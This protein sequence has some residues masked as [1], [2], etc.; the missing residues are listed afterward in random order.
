MRLKSALTA[1]WLCLLAGCALSWATSAQALVVHPFAGSFGGEGS[2]SGQFKEP[3]G[4]AVNDT[5]HGVYVVDSANRRVQEFNSTGSTV[6]GEFNGS[7]A[8]TGV[9]SHP[10]QIAVDNS[11]NPLD[12][13]AG[14]VYVV[15]LGH[16]VVDK[17]TASGTYV[18]Q[19]TGTPSS[20]F[21]PFEASGAQVFGGRGE[22]G[23][24]RGLA[25]DPSGAV[26]VVWGT[27]YLKK[28]F[29]KEAYVDNFSD[30][31]ENQYVAEHPAGFALASLE[32]G[33][34][35][36]GE[37]DL[38]LNAERIRKTN[39]SG[40]TLIPTIDSERAS[41]VAVDPTGGEVYVDN[42]NY[43]NP[44]DSIIGAFSL[45]GAQIEQFG[46]GH[47]NGSS[48]VAVDGSDGT[49]YATSQSLDAVAIFNAV[50]LPSVTIGA[51]TE[52]TPRS[53]TLNGIVA[54][55]GQA[56]T[57]C[58]FEYG[59]TSAY[60]Q[61]VPCS[62]ASLGTGSSPVAVSAQ[63]TGLTPET[64]YHY[65]LV[66]TNTGGRSPTADRE[67]FTGP[68]IGGEFV[69][70]VASSSA[71]LQ[72][73][74]D[75][76]G[77]D[78]HYYFEYGTTESYGTDAPTAA[79]GLDIGSAS[80]VQT[81]S[82]HLQELQ[83]SS[84]YHYRFVA[85]QGGETFAGPDRSFT[86]QPAGGG[87][88]SLPD[89]R[90][91][92]L[93]S[94]PNKKGSLID[95]FP[96]DPIQAASDGSGIAYEAFEPIGENTP[97]GRSQLSQILSERGRDGW[98][99]QDISLPH[100]LA[101]EEEIAAEGFDYRLFSPDLSLAAIEQTGATAFVPLSPEAAEGNKLYLRDN[102]SGNYTPLLTLANVPAG[103]KLDGQAG[104]AQRSELVEFGAATPDLS[105]VVIKSS[106]ALTPEAVEQTH[107]PGTS[108]DHSLYEWGS[109][110]L[111]LV[112]ILPNGEP[113]PAGGLGANLAGESHSGFGSALRAVSNDGRWVAWTIGNPYDG[114]DSKG[115]YFYYNGLYVR[116]MVDGTT[117]HVGGAR[118]KFLTIS[119][120]GSMV[121]FLENGELYEFD[122]GTG[123]QTDL[124][125]SHGHNAGESDAGV[126]ETLLGIS[127]DGSNVYLVATGV[128]ANGAVS[129]GDN[130]Y[131][132]HDDGVERTTSYIATLSSQDEFDWSAG[133]FGLKSSEDFAG[134]KSRV[135]PDGRYLTF[136]STKS[137]TGYDNLDANSGVPD[138]EVYLYDAVAGRL[139]CASCDPTGARPV[140]TLDSG[141]LLLLDDGLAGNDPFIGRWLAGII[142]GWDTAHGARSVYQPRFLSDRGRLFF[143]SPDALV[144]QD[145]NGLM[146]VYEYEPLGVG[147]CVAKSVTFS[148]HSN[149]CVSLISSGTS[150]SESG[151]FDASENG[152]DV[153]FLTS[154]RL[155]AADYDTGI[156]VYDAHVCSS[157]VPCVPVPVSAPP[158]TS[159]DSCKAAPSPQPAIF[160]AAPSATFNG[161]GNISAS[162]KV[163][164]TVKTLTRAQR[165]ASAL[166][167]CRKKSRSKR[168][169]C[170]QRARRRYRAK[171]SRNRHVTKKGKG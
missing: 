107:L 48:G 74:I 160:G 114:T 144:P 82:L 151:F 40:E 112:N 56:V 125:A 75:P 154:S 23:G 32:E 2:G 38:Y 1:A 11:A 53:L 90:A 76:N 27:N 7:A 133:S 54:S 92:E 150:N 42:P 62:P 26:W 68:I 21:G 145:T 128:L 80:G 131:L 94:P 57:S 141:S 30:A 170:E 138:E 34:A 162:S 111:Q 33:L 43:N 119:S 97:M 168:A 106:L 39:S 6:L 169:V 98:E 50:T 124:T 52:Q 44:A 123:V 101:P 147:D 13:S 45:S 161:A 135:S 58:I 152:D 60:G 65:R 158:C 12:P 5:T 156:D 37:G 87:G 148:E 84:V 17:F 166:R 117:V 78:T 171:Q 102:T 71:T 115:F 10:T 108:A 63:V 104:E 18:G 61:S 28:E 66:A 46:A 105:H 103:V 143:D 88:L 165:L 130:V 31:L 137:L 95:G 20:P 24:I 159:G 22:P 113:Q 8:P 15:D 134:V 72:A 96:M 19:L 16:D 122:T 164:V 41:G 73:P 70:N 55:E 85:V 35:V 49:V 126:K 167:A 163:A 93:V 9:F 79:P 51:V 136:M 29:V 99:T 129:G 89:G 83:P 64:T 67:L 109:G 81:I 120:D 69:V 155:S 3:V 142:P 110:T 121:F 153:F 157:A 25:V 47:V 100:R 86:T 91:W 139:V 77:T 127:E 132:I 4:V 14:D 146:D 140:G 116:D 118:A 59:T 149:G 36:D